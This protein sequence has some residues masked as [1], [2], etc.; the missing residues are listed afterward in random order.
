MIVAEVL[1]NLR[2]MAPGW[3]PYRFDLAFDWPSQADE[4][5]ICR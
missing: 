2:A 1:K 3:A 4:V 5:A